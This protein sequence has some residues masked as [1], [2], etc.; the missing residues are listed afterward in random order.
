MSSSFWWLSFPQEVSPPA[1]A[2]KELWTPTGCLRGS[3]G[4]PNMA[5]WWLKGLTSSTWANWPITE[6]TGEEVESCAANHMDARLQ[7][8]FSPLFWVL[9][10]QPLLDSLLIRCKAMTEANTLQGESKNHSPLLIT[11]IKSLVCLCYSCVFIYIDYFSMSV[12]SSNLLFCFYCSSFQSHRSSGFM[13]YVV[14]LPVSLS[15][16]PCFGHDVHRCVSVFLSHPSSS[17][18]CIQ[19]PS[20]TQQRAPQTDCLTLPHRHFFMSHVK[21][22]DLSRCQIVFCPLPQHFWRSLSLYCT[23]TVRHNGLICNKAMQH[24]GQALPLVDVCLS[25]LSMKK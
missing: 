10:T 5:I 15:D 18:V 9:F 1:A 4:A 16:P 7:M 22:S 20:L 14:Y 6:A 13:K 25:F 11:S 2:R 21:I 19:R 23:E 3:G 17:S 8:Y 12:M 24:P